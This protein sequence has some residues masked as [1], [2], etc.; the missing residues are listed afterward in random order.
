MIE[1]LSINYIEMLRNFR[2]DNKTIKQILAVLETKIV[3]LCNEIE[4][5]LLL[6]QYGVELTYAILGYSED[7]TKPNKEV[8]EK[9]LKI[10]YMI[11]NILSLQDL[12]LLIWLRGKRSKRFWIT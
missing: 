11:E 12:I 9:I 10:R 6:N 2:L 5:K 4:I 8:L 7:F 3:K 1:P